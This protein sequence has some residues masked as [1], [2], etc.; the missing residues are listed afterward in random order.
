MSQ[1]YYVTSVF[2][3]SAQGVV[4]GTITWLI[5]CA[6]AGAIATAAA[7][8]SI[9]DMEWALALAWIGHLAVAGFGLWGLL[10][11]CIHA[12][13]LAALVQGTERP[14]RVLSIAFISQLTTS[15][16]VAVT[17]DPE[18]LVRVMVVWAVFLV[19][20]MVFLTGRFRKQTP[21]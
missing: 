3:E 9:E 11:V 5:T 12:G 2:R 17:F 6:L 4:G 7:A 21:E 8:G 20:T 18:G 15:A 16:I 13:C 1:S 14:L 19:P 10:V